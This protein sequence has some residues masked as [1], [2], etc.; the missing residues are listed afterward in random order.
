[1]DPRFS[2]WAE[3][4]AK[5]AEDPAFKAHAEK[6]R[7]TDAERVQKEHDRR[8]SLLAAGIPM[9]LWDAISAPQETDALAA[10]RSF[11]STPALFLVL[12]G[13]AGRGK[14]YAAAW[15][16]AEQEGR[17]V[18]AH[19]LVAAGTFDGVWKEIAAA[20]FLA[21]DE[22]GAE[23]RNPAFEASL[24]SMLNSRHANGRKTVICTNLDG[25]TFVQRYCAKAGDPLRD[26]L[27]TSQAWV[28][29]PGESMRKHFTD[30]DR[31]EEGQP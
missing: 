10:A 24:Y 28:A 20:P 30:T 11:L 19:D 14:T 22:L 21:L 29:L 6:W 31:D 5:R 17:Y 13:P 1:M 9:T 25:A 27:R 3:R 2:D 26:R 8:H 4:C 16:V 18:L 7:E 15:A 23:Y 12:S